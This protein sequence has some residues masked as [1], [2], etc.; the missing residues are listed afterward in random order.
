MPRP[1]SRDKRDLRLGMVTASLFEASSH[2][3][4]GAKEEVRNNLVI[5]LVLEFSP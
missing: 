3:P 4:K 5:P 2:E 1:G